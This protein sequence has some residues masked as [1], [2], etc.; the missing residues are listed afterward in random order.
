MDLEHLSL[1]E[2]ACLFEQKHGRPIT[3]EALGYR[4]KKG[5]TREEALAKPPCQRGMSSQRKKLRAGRKARRDRISGRQYCYLHID[6]PG[7]GYQPK[8]RYVG[9]GQGGRCLHFLGR[10]KDHADWISTWFAEPTYQRVEMGISPRKLLMLDWIDTKVKQMWVV[11]SHP[12]ANA[13]N[14]EQQLLRTYNQGHHKLF[15]RAVPM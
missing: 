3:P 15:N 13:R 1:V 14:F 10:E 6:V 12:F 11:V 9:L 7:G 8:V 5:M 4:L 2:L